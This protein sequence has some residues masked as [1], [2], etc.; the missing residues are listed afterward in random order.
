MAGGSRGKDHWQQ[1]PDGGGGS[2]GGGAVPRQSAGV[3]PPVG[4]GGQENVGKGEVEGGD[5]WWA[6]GV[7]ARAVD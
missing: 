1:Q 6:G 5:G 7:A 3:G 2:A 4:G